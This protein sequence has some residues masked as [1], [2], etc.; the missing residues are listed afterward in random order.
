[1][2]VCQHSFLST[3]WVTVLLSCLIPALCLQGFP[4]DCLCAAFSHG[5]VTQAELLICVVRWYSDTGLQGTGPQILPSV[6]EVPAGTLKDYWYSDT[7]AQILASGLQVPEA[8]CGTI[9]ILIQDY[10]VQEHRY[11]T[12]LLHILGTGPCTRYFRVQD[13]RRIVAPFL[14]YRYHQVSAVEL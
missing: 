13:Y 3:L 6:Q 5:N 7:G 8:L 12:C 2:F 14:D 11:C 4:R 9:G 10:G 1:M